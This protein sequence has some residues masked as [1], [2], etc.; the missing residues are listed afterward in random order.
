MKRSTKITL[1]ALTALPVASSLVFYAVKPWS[2]AGT[3]RDDP[4]GV[5]GLLVLAVYLLAG[6]GAV[7]SLGLTVVYLVH[8]SRR[9]YLKGEMQAWAVLFI[10]FGILTQPV[11]WYLNVW[12]EPKLD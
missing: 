11:Y 5:G 4:H 3:M 2:A 9:E 7:L 12:R 1:G 6:A 10:F 8:C